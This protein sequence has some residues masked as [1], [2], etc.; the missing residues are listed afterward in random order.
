MSEVEHIQD[1]GEA[2]L[3]LMKLFAPDVP[4][5][6]KPQYLKFFT[7]LLVEKDRK[8]TQITEADYE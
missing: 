5:E 6:S 2:A 3:K 1:T 7:W 4:R 8:S